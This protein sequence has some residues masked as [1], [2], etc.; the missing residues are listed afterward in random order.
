MDEFGP[1]PPVLSRR[2][3]ENAFDRLV[4]HP[5]EQTS[6]LIDLNHAPSFKNLPPAYVV[7]AEYDVLRDEGEYFA[8]RLRENN[9]LVSAPKSS[10][11]FCSPVCLLTAPVAWLHRHMIPNQ[12]VLCA[13]TMLFMLTS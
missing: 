9:V 2:M 4:Q 6:E 11:D 12:F 5:D 13:K 3:C 8:A 7:T 10:V 1:T